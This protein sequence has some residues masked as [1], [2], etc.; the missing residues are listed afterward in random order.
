M[1]LPMVVNGFQKLSSGLQTVT[2]ATSL[3]DAWQKVYN[4]DLALGA[5]ISGLAQKGLL[6]LKSAVIGL[7]QA[8]VAHPVFAFIAGFTALTGII[9][10]VTRSFK[11]LNAEKKLLNLINH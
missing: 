7:G 6:G 8:M 1:G 9:S 4:G 2:G 10:T 3:A 5:K 11:Q